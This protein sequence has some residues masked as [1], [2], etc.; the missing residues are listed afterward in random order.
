[1]T[2][3]A[4]PRGGPAARRVSGTHRLDRARLGGEVERARAVHGVV[5]V[6]VGAGAADAAAAV[7]REERSDRRRVVRDRG[8]V[9]RRHRGDQRVARGVVGVA[10]D[11]EHDARLPA[12]LERLN[13]HRDGLHLCLA[14]CLALRPLGLRGRAAR[15]PGASGGLSKRA[16]R[17][18]ASARQQR[19]R[20]DH[21]M[22]QSVPGATRCSESVVRGLLC[23]DGRAAA[24]GTQGSVFFLLPAWQ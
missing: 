4:R 22:I 14:A 8:A 24:L 18:G 15:H 19:S 17:H 11:H 6:D 12:A 3:G 20:S 13:E 5:C 21:N 9:K 7:A 1:M 23:T 10:V 2:I 16:E